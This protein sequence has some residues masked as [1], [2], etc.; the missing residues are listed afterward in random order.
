MQRL[1]KAAPRMRREC[2]QVGYVYQAGV[3]PI[4]K[5]CGMLAVDRIGELCYCADHFDKWT[6]LIK[7][8]KIMREERAAQ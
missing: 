7:W 8:V 1:G 3:K 4:P 6:E 2:Q 5:V